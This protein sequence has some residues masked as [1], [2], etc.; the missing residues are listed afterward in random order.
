MENLLAWVDLTP[1]QF[2]ICAGVIFLAGVVR[3][4][5]GFA[6]SALVMA[7]LAI[8][9]P[10]IEL[11]AVCWFLELSASAIMVRGGFREADMKV[12]AGLIIGSALGSPIGLYLTTTLPVETSKAVALLLILVLAAT[13]LLKLRPKFLATGPGLYASGLM[14]GIASGLASVGGMIVA[15]YVL[16]RDAPAR[17]MRASLVMFLFASS[18]MSFIFLYYYGMMVSVA[19]LRGL[20]FAVPCMLGVLAGQ[21]LFM[22]RLEGYYRPFCLALLMFLAALGLVRLGMGG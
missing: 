14:A 16:A 19:A 5:S 9:I 1:V 21:A 3:G 15:L 13:Q 12:V 4:F 10:P 6:L 22:P 2:W 20:V 17:I 8:M 11:I 18:V 7:S